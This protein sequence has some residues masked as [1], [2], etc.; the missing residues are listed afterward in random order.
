MEIEKRI[1]KLEHDYYVEEYHKKGNRF[2]YHREDGP[3]RIQYRKDNSILF[4]EYLVNDK[5]HREDGP[6][7]II[8][9]KDGSIHYKK[10]YINGNQLSEEDWEKEYGWKLHLKGTPMGEIFK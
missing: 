6:A 2:Y 8:Y 9:N 5:L 7:L 3:A 1:V 10:Y 4:R